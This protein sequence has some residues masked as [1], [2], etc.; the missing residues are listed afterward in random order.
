[1]KERERER[2]IYGEVEEKKEME[3]LKKT[4]T[5]R[6]LCIDLHVFQSLIFL[7]LSFSHAQVRR[8]RHDDLK[9]CFFGKHFI[10]SAAVSYHLTSSHIYIYEEYIAHVR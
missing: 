2:Q 10:S 1:M 9:H 5:R 6:R 8:R 4:D 3:Y 7:S